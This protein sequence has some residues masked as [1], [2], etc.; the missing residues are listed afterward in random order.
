MNRLFLWLTDIEEY[1]I[2]N[3]VSYPDVVRDVLDVAKKNG[4]ECSA[5]FERSQCE[6]KP[7]KGISLEVDDV[8]GLCVSA[9]IDE[10]YFKRTTVES[11][12]KLGDV[13]NK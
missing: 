1:A 2:K 7:R 11:W 9:G 5:D 10:S 3:S 13:R 8:D 4:Y 12:L 6:G